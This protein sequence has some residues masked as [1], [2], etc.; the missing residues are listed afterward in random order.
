MMVIPCEEIEACYNAFQ[1]TSLQLMT[2]FITYH[3]VPR[4]VTHNEFIV[5]LSNELKDI[6]TQE[7]M[8]N[9]MASSHF[10][11]VRPVMTM[12]DIRSV[13]SSNCC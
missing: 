12:S 13:S 3:C 5:P 8:G 9:S 2:I 6:Y 4:E 1:I 11:S 7:G 10:E